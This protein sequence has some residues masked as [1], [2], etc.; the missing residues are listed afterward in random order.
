MV[1]RGPFTG[2]ASGMS[3]TLLGG[4]ELGAHLRPTSGRGFLS[5]PQLFSLVPS[6]FLGL[7]LVQVGL[8]P[9]GGSEGCRVQVLR[10][11]RGRV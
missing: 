7:Q 1:P 8:G 9:L 2:V 11:L 5:P 3:R 10:A 6:H 4:P